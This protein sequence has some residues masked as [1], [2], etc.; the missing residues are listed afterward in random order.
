MSP[1]RRPVRF[2]LARRVPL[3][4]SLARSRSRYSLAGA[5]GCPS[6]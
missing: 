6:P 5:T 4:A 2:S 1:P 3:E